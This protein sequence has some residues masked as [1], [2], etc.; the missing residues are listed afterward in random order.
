[1]NV[2][3]DKPEYN[4]FQP[5]VALR[6]ENGNETGI[7]STEVFA[8]RAFRRDIGTSNYSA[9][10]FGLSL[11]GRRALTGPNILTYSATGQQIEYD[12]VTNQS[13]PTAN[14]KLGL[15]RN[16]DR[17]LSLNGGFT[18]GR[19]LP[20]GDSF[21]YRS[22]GVEA[23]VGKL[24]TGGW[25]TYA[26]VEYGVRWYDARFAATGTFRNDRYLSLIGSVLNSTF[27]WN[28]FSPRLS[29]AYNTNASNVAFYDYDA[30]ECYVAF[31]RGF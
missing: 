4:V 18:F 14:F 29:C 10:T 30:V 23:G 9:N 28:G 15:V 17:T 1:M 22:V 19:A 11:S 2:I 26:G 16:V 20:E 24:W 8:R 13:G 12:T 6:F 25:T 27:S 31:T 7:W 3:Y 5:G 21:K